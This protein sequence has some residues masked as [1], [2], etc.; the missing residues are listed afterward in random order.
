MRGDAGH[1]IDVES[2]RLNAERA[3][4]PLERTR[5]ILAARDHPRQWFLAFCAN[6]LDG[7]IADLFEFTSTVSP[8]QQT[9]RFSHE[10]PSNINTNISHLRIWVLTSILPLKTT[11][12]PCPEKLQR[13]LA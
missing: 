9:L 4:R 13:T 5:H 11:Q 3:K 1:H 2:D 8:L 10:S 6:F 7:K 12:R